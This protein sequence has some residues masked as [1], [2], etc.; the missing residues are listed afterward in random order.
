MARLT[1]PHSQA[2]Q[3][4]A[5]LAPFVLSSHLEDEL[6]QILLLFLQPDH[7]S[8]SSLLS[9]GLSVNPFRHSEERVGTE[10]RSHC[11]RDTSHWAFLG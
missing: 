6:L 9:P 3:L 2:G 11:W 4:R 5:G 7:G 1:F 10:G 8:E